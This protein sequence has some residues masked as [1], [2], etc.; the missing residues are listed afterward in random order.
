MPAIFDALVHQQGL[1]PSKAWRVSYLI[2]FSVI[3]TVAVGM[4]IFCDDTPS[5][6]WADRHEAIAQTV[7]EELRGNS[8]VISTSKTPVDTTRQSSL[9]DL[10]Q[11]D[12]E[13]KGPRV[14]VYE[15]PE[16]DFSDI[17]QAKA[18]VV[19]E[20]T[21]REALAVVFSRETFA[22]AAPYACSFGTVSLPVTLCLC[23]LLT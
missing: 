23:C 9:T 22:L 10:S 1:S 14:Q 5:G 17:T 15:V 21:V 19:V 2:P 7:Q 12:F 13:K 18:E 16:E 4:A 8:S 6:R 3:I 11:T 20:P